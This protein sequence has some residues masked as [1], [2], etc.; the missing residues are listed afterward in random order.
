[1]AEKNEVRLGDFVT[2]KKHGHRG[3][4]FMIH[5]NFKETGESMDW[6]R[7]LVPALEEATLTE[8]WISILCHGG[9]AVQV[10]ESDVEAWKAPFEFDNPWADTYFR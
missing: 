9:G 2:T 7:G 3:R 8:R 4:V 1:M 6:F 5:H 10:P